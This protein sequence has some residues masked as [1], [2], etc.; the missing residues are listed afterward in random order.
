[1][2]INKEQLLKWIKDKGA[3]V[4]YVEKFTH[5]DKNLNVVIEPLIYFKPKVFGKS[6][7]RSYIKLL[8]LRTREDCDRLNHELSAEI[9]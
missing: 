8:G 7:T 5:V 2:E 9:L 3:R 1:M 6:S 4:V